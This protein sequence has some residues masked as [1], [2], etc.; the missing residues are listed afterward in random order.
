MQKII[1]LKCLNATK[2][3]DLMK[4]TLPFCK[5]CHQTKGVV[6]EAPAEEAFP[7]GVLHVVIGE[8]PSHERICQLILKEKLWVK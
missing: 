4:Q 5:T 2:W 7:Q 6:V 8:G 3:P 1:H